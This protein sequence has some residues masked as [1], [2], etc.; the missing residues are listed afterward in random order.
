MER[1]RNAETL[2]TATSL[3]RSALNFTQ[4]LGAMPSRWPVCL[5][6]AHCG[7]QNQIIGAQ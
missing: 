4:S 3:A 1:R 2:G 5:C 6:C 7:A